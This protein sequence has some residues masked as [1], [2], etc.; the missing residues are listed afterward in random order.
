M[1]TSISLRF[2][3]SLKMPRVPVAT[4]F[5]VNERNLMQFGVLIMVSKMF[6]PTAS[7]PAVNPHAFSICATSS[8]TDIFLGNS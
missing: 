8:F 2:A 1:I 5:P 4:R 7:F 6:V 3:S